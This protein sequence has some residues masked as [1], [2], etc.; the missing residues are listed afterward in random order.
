MKGASKKSIDERGEIREIKQNRI[1]YLKYCTSTMLLLR[2]EPHKICIAFIAVVMESS[3][4]MNAL[5][6]PP[7]APTK[8]KKKSLPPSPKVRLKPTD[9]PPLRIS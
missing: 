3:G 7:T 5:I 8:K 6:Q 2:R 4:F 1:G 9:L